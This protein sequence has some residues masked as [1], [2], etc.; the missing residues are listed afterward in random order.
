M[1]TYITLANYTD[2]GIR[3]IKE[4]PSRVD[5]A[6]EVAK[7]FGGELKEFYLTM[8]A[9]DIVSISEAPD[10][11]TAAKIALTLGSAGNV[12]TITLRAF[13][14]AEFGEIVAGIS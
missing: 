6:K 11:E 4:A 9:Y 10:D 14:E 13:T 7:S 5:A 8:G 1:A 12:R 3:A 2:Q